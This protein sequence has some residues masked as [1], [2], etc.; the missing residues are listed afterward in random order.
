MIINVEGCQN[1]Q[2]PIALERCYTPWQFTSVRNFASSQSWPSVRMCELQDWLEARCPKL[3]AVMTFADALLRGVGQVVFVGSPLC[4][5]VIASALFTYNWRTA[6]FGLVSLLA[7]TATAA[8]LHA[9][10]CKGF[11]GYTSGLHGFN[12][13]LFG[14]GVGELAKED[15]NSEVIWVQLQTTTVCVLFGMCSSILTCV[16]AKRLHPSPCFTLP[17]NLCAIWFFG[18]T[19]AYSHWATN[20]VFEPRLPFAEIN[21]RSC[22]RSARDGECDNQPLLAFLVGALRGVSQIF[23]ANST[24]CGATMLAGMAVCS[25]LVAAA[26]A[27][28]S[29]TGI[30]TGMALGVDGSLLYNGLWGFNPALTAVAIGGGVFGPGRWSSALFGTFGAVMTTFLHG[31]LGSLMVPAGL[32]A[33][34]LPF[35]LTAL[36]LMSVGLHVPEQNSSKDAPNEEV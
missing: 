13:I 16:L 34:T 24:A 18:G 11:E 35:C 10:G 33:F 30:V 20:A 29:G 4:G 23:F 7:G 19:V 1:Q 9:S 8:A 27:V 36:L 28:G 2:E 25:P 15:T 14:L 6:S 22:L 31:T 12:A 32:P 5:L 17:F 21:I 3:A 26:A